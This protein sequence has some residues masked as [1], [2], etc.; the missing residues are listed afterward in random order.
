MRFARLSLV[1]LLF[2]GVVFYNVDLPSGAEW[3]TFAWVSVLGATACTL[4]GM[5]L[6]YPL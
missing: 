6:P 2:I 3:F 1:L 4:L 5:T